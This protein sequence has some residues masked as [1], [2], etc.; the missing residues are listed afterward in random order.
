MWDNFDKFSKTLASAQVYRAMLNRPTK[1]YF[2]PSDVKVSP[3]PLKFR[4]WSKNVYG[5]YQGLCPLK[6]DADDKCKLGTFMSVYGEVKI[7]NFD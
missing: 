3:Q 7:G 6:G 4:K 5:W 1:I 2:R